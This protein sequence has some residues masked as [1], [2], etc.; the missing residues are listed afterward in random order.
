MPDVDI[1]FRVEDEFN[2]TL[3]RFYRQLEQCAGS[4]ERLQHESHG[5]TSGTREMSSAA[6]S[7]S[8]SLGG[9]GGAMLVVNQAL[10]AFT[11]LAEP[12][13]Q[14]LDD[15]GDK[16]RALIM[17]GD[18]A[19]R[20]FN[21]FAQEMAQSMGRAEGEIRKAG[22]KW[23]NIG[24]GGEG[25]KELTQLADRFSNLNPDKDFSSVA[26]T[27]AD[28]VKNKSVSGLAD[29][30]GGGEGVELKL[31]SSGVE[32]ALRRGDVSGAMEKFK[33]VADEFGYTQK[34]ADEM[35]NTFDRKITKI[36]ERIKSIVMD[37]VSD[38]VDIVEPYVDKLI[39]FLNRDD[40]QQFFEDLKNNAVEASAAL[41]A[42]VDTIVEGWDNIY[43]AVKPFGST[44]ENICEEIFP[45]MADSSLSFVDTL[46]G[47]LVGGTTQIIAGIVQLV[48]MGW[49]GIIELTE[50]GV[51]VIQSAAESVANGVIWVANGMRSGVLYVVRGMVQGILDLID[52]VAD[53]PLGEKLGLDD[54]IKSLQTAVDAIDKLN[55]D[56]IG[57]VK[58]ERPDFSDSKV[59]VIDSVKIS[60]D[61]IASAI[62]KVHGLVKNNFY[63]EKKDKDKK[64]SALKRIN[65]DT[66][67]LVAMGQKEQDLRWMKEMAEQRFINEI[68]LRQLTP[69]INVS[70]KGT[71]NQTPSD[72][73]KS[74]AA[75]L[76]RMAD[77]GTF[78]AYG[79]V[80]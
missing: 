24:I 17:L 80:G 20:E 72:Y 11:R 6:R 66:N 62:D 50:W 39:D 23:R 54:T 79:N 75:E 33:K 78:N 16:Q 7:S 14:A 10:Q 47:I 18:E 26:D 2:E 42:L 41:I 8:F 12:V 1:E 35:G 40:V 44:L 25:I 37:T 9:F 34:K 68:N 30:L 38:I 70:V 27:F 31:Q 61:M 76:Q 48:Q 55:A 15:I 67:K 21:S 74:L 13:K 19:G 73:A 3:E 63:D 29:L 49:N 32:R 22:L 53:T 36:S 4:A 45:Y 65:N 71:S 64:D 28:A 69:T 51:D 77:A 5:S 56:K 60:S 43:E 58:F 59:E 57:E 52:V 46:V